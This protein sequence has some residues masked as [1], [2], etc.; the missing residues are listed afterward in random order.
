M[1]VAGWILYIFAMYI[2][3]ISNTT[4]YYDK[5]LYLSMLIVKT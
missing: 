1:A 5:Y 3:D 4:I 2:R